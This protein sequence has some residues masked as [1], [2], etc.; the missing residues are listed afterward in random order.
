[1]YIDIEGARGADIE[2]ARGVY[3]DIEGLEAQT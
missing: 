1:M 2:G 3:I